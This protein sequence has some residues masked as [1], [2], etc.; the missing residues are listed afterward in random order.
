[1]QPDSRS[2][3][4]FDVAAYWRQR[5]DRGGNS[6]AGSYGRLAHYKASFLNGFVALNGVRSLMDFGCGDSHQAS[7]FVVPAYVGIDVS[8]TA[9]AHCRRR[10][11]GSAAYEFHGPGALASLPQC[12]LTIS[13]DV[14]YHLVTDADFEHYVKVL[15]S[16]AR[17]YCVIYSSNLEANWASPHVRHRAFTN[18]IRSALPQWRLAAH[19]PN[20]FPFEPADVNNTSFADFFVY[21][22]EPDDCLVPSPAGRQTLAAASPAGAPSVLNTTAE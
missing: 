5:Y 7:L 10:F 8:E 1:M 16:M 19:V 12:D 6:G 9:L 13:M 21:V 4:G 15:F 22:M 14:I 18:Y 17:K 20:P 2:D 11:A 3:P